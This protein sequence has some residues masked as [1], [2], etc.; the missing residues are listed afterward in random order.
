MEL[1]WEKYGK[2]WSKKI[3]GKK[4]EKFIISWVGEK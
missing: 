4:L 2:W 3:S 1:I